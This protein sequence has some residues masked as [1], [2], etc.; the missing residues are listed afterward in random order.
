ML[1]CLVADALF[2]VVGAGLDDMLLFTAVA[3]HSLFYL[4]QPISHFHCSSQ[5]SRNVMTAVTL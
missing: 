3:L 1:R 4:P 5:P 2:T